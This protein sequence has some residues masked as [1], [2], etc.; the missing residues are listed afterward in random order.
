MDKDKKTDIG[1]EPNQMNPN[2]A[3]GQGPAGADNSGNT[4]QNTPKGP[5]ICNTLLIFFLITFVP[6]SYTHQTL[7]TKR[8]V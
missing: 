8:V 7:P 5:N 6:V 4:E 2:S 3:G 1:Q